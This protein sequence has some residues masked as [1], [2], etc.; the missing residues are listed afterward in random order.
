MQ[1]T[2]KV[3]LGSSITEFKN[4]RA[5]I[6]N[7]IYR[8]SREFEKNYNVSVDPLLC[9]SFDD[10]YTKIRK[11]EEYNEKVRGSDF[12]Y[13]IFFTK[14]GEYTREEFAVARKQFEL[15]DK[16]KIY[17]YFKALGNEK[18]EDSLAEF[19]EELDKTFGHY[20]GS[21]D[22]IDTVKLRIL[23]NLKLQ[24]MDFLEVKVDGDF[25]VVDG[26]KALSLKNVSEFANNSIFQ[27]LKAE[28]EKTE[29]R[30][31]ELKAGYEKGE[32]TSVQE[33]EYTNVAAKRQN[34]IDS[35]EEL[36]EN[37]FNM[38]L[39]MCRDEARGEITLRQRE[40]YRLFEAGDLEGANNILDFS[41]IKSDYLRRKAIREAEQKKDAQVF[42]REG[43]T[44]IDILTAMRTLPTRFEEIEQIYDEIIQVAFDERVEFGT[45][46]DFAWFLYDQNKHLKAYELGKKLEK[47]FADEVVEEDIADIYHLI[48]TICR[49]YASKKDETESYYLKAIAI[50]EK[51]AESN[52]ERLNSDLA[53]S[54]NNAGNFYADQDQPQKAEEYYLRA[55]AIT[56]KLAKTNPDRFNPALATS[57]N[58][59]GIFYDNQ[60][61]PQKAEEYFLRAMEIREKL[62]ESNP[63]RFNPDLA[64]SCNNAGIFYKTQ[65][66]PQKAEEYYLRAIAIREK[67]A[68]LNP[69]R[70]NSA[71]ATSCN[72]AGIF[73]KNQGQPQKAE[74][75]Y[76]RAIAIYEKLA[77]S[78]PERFNPDLAISCNNVG[79]FYA[80]QGWPQKAE[81]YFL[82]AIAIYEKLAESNPE[83]FNPDL[84]MSCNNAGIFYKTQGQPQKAEGYYLRAIAI[85]EKLAESNPDRFNPDFADGCNNA[86]NFYNDQD[87]P[88]KAEEYYLR[89]M[90]IREKLA[91]SNPERFNPDLAGSYNNAGNFYADQGQP[92]KAEGYYL[93]AIAITEKLA[94]SNPDRFNPALAT[95]C[96][97][98]GKFYSTQGQPQKADGY[99]IRSIAI[100]EQLAES[101]P[102][103]F[104]PDF[105]TSCNNAGIFYETQGQPQKAEEYYLKA[106][107]IREKLAESNPERFNPDLATSYFNYAI[108]T[109]DD[110]F[111]EKALALAKTCPSNP[112][113]KRIIETPIAMK[114]SDP[115]KKSK[116][117]GFMRKIFRRLK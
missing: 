78:N 25:C 77:E 64:T 60:G 108:F 30:Y 114:E 45:V 4:E 39:R 103:R 40:A 75:Y 12:C 59:A 104:N 76:L 14:A 99:Y 47:A 21:F 80:D 20:Y 35:L 27:G 115:K 117:G 95:S 107:A 19:M 67:L 82:R 87:Q 94:K 101:N 113:C 54:C 79:I 11:Q 83:R 68:K 7:F 96:N 93:R 8:L 98:A 58:N 71:L 69:E 81:G 2:I 53:D 5:D 89:A 52:P 102:E 70:F 28:L 97:N 18:P 73:Y 91:E 106:I 62:A 48:G 36:R 34:L 44:K 46:L 10:A 55:I 22:H 51:I 6:E 50:R 61:Q 49:D 43:R 38:S 116:F 57:C 9:E 42:V 1:K 84:A 32:C 41:E 86:G 111:F 24:E 56:E 112:Y 29:V 37:I 92:Q 31:F 85:Y 26:K 100:Y 72:S 13:F 33:R 110:S 15:T 66:Q 23:L 90:E 109:D 16:P 88:Q 65:G 3:F 74:E 105:A 17:T 63:E